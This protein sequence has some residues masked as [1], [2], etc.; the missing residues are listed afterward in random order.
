ML[1]LTLSYDHRVINGADAG[2]FLHFWWKK[3]QIFAVW[4]CSYLS[5]NFAASFAKYVGFI[6][7]RAL[8][9]QQ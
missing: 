7:A 9:S 2:R 1:P 3:F 5:N 4:C 6:G 8:E